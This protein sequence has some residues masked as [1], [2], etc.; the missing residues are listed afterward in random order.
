MATCAM[1]SD[2]VK[3]TLPQPVSGHLSLEIFLGL[4]G[5]CACNGRNLP[6]G[7]DLTN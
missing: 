5:L 1:L 6:L 2:L 4:Q 7:G 3:I